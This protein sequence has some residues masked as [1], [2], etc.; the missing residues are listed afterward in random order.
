M[1]LTE[2]YTIVYIIRNLYEKLCIFTSYFLS[3]RENKKYINK[4]F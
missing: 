4:Y 3:C 2:L 1:F